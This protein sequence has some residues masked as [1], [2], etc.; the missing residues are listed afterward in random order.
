M[1]RVN[2][3]AEL[4]GSPHRREA[5]SA[6]AGLFASKLCSHKGDCELMVGIAVA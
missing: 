1:N 3:G 4:V 2:M 5:F 6:L